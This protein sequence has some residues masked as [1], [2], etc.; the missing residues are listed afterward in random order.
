MAVE[1]VGALAMVDLEGRG[2][3]GGGCG[4]EVMVK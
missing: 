1:L 2:G 3:G 4:G